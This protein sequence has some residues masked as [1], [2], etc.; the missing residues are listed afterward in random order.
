MNGVIQNAGWV[1]HLDSASVNYSLTRAAS[2]TRD[3]VLT[4]VLAPRSR[5]CQLQLRSIPGAAI[6]QARRSGAV[7]I[8]S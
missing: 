1:I 4:Q 2:S 7:L 5:T 3:Q 6:G 8:A